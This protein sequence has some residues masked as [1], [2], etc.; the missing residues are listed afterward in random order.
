MTQ[1]TGFPADGI[2]Q[3][4]TVILDRVK[5]YGIGEELWLNDLLCVEER[6]RGTRVT[7]ISVQYNSTDV[8]GVAVPLDSV[9]TLAL[10]DLTITLT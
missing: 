5:E 8:D 2:A 6:V 10:A 9:W 1:R 4:R 7:A 3:L